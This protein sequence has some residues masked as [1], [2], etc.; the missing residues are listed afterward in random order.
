MK[1]TALFE[2]DVTFRYD[3]VRYRVRVDYSWCVGCPGDRFEPG[4]PAHSD[5]CSLLE[6]LEVAVIVEDERHG[7]DEFVY[8]VPRPVEGWGRMEKK[9]RDMIQ[10]NKYLRRE[11]EAYLDERHAGVR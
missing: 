5:L 7:G 2:Q 3:D 9:L 4:E 6:V 11:I 8:Q 1:T 10:R